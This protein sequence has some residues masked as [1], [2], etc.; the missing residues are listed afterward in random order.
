MIGVNEAL[1]FEPVG[2]LGEFQKRLR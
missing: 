2:R 1:G